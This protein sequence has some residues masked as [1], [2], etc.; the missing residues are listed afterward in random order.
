MAIEGGLRLCELS[1]EE[2]RRE[3]LSEE[4]VRKTYFEKDD[5]PV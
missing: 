1:A 5:L 4:D 2:E 3:L